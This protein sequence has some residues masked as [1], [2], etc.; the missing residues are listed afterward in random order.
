MNI[1]KNL[2]KDGKRLFRELVEDFNITDPAGLQYLATAGECLDRMKEAQA[3]IKRHGVLVE[4]RY[5]ALKQN[6][7]CGIE[8]DAR[9][10]M[11][12]ALKALNLDVEPLKDGPGRPGGR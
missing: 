11:L 7:A 4:D 6:P 3:E 1:P 5:K 12:A 8:K 2:K 10:G 9:N